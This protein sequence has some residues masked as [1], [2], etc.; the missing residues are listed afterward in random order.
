MALLTLGDAADLTD[1]A[2]QKIFLKQTELE[3]KTYFDKYYNVETG[4]VD[5]LLKDSSLSGIGQAARIV[6]NAVITSEA[7]VQGYDKTYTQVEFGKLLP[8]PNKCGNLVLRKEILKK[9][10]KH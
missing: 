8:V 10:P 3:K 7:P 5:R 1:V 2:I 4:V 9:L 6:E